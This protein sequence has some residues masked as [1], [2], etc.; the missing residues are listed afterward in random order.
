M[1][2]SRSGNIIALLSVC[3]VVLLAV[4]CTS[5]RIRR[6]LESKKLVGINLSGF[7]LYNLNLERINLTRARLIRTNFCFCNLR[8]AQL[9][10]ADLREADLCA[11][12]LT[13]AD[14]RGAN[15][16]GASLHNAVLK[17]AILV[18]AYFYDA[19][20][21]DA[22]L[23][24]AIMVSGVDG[25][26]GNDIQKKIDRGEI[27]QFVHLRNADCAGTAIDVKWKDF[28]QNQRVK[29]FE[30]IIWVD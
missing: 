25:V 26:T 20:L 9:V 7:D 18:D 19:D 16:R 27:V 15:F 4:E 13:Q 28:I 21:S 1:I 3:V 10:N 12:D 5:G 8:S 23:R 17:K 11:A 14:L 30:K 29:N 24:E 2:D 6:L 22:D